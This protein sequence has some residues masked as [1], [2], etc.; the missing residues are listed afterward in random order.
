MITHVK[1]TEWRDFGAHNCPKDLIVELLIINPNIFLSYNDC[2]SFK[3]L[4][5]YTTLTE[6]YQMNSFWYARSSMFYCARLSCKS[7]SHWMFLLLCELRLHPYVAGAMEWV[8][9]GGKDGG[10]Q[11]PSHIPAYSVI[12][13]GGINAGRKEERNKAAGRSS[14]PSALCLGGGGGRGEESQVCFS[15]VKPTTHHTSEPMACRYQLW[16]GLVGF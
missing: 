10:C 7:G 11:I 8:G 13:Q 3:F 14:S 4:F 1:T 6:L 12:K 16:W 15:L 9:G 2:W 5:F